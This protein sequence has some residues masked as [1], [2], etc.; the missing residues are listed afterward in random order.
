[1][2]EELVNAWM[3]NNPGKT[4]DQAINA[5]SQS[6]GGKNQVYLGSSKKEIIL[7][8]M[9]ELDKATGLPSKRK[10]EFVESPDILSTEQMYLKF[11]TDKTTKSKAMALLKAMGQSHLGE[12]GA[13]QV[14]KNKVDESAEIYAGGKGY[15]VTP[16]ELT[17]MTIGSLNLGKLPESDTTKYISRTTDA[18]KT[19]TLDDEVQNLLGRKLTSAE[20]KE[21]LASV[22]KLENKGTVTSSKTDP[23]TGMKTVLQEDKY[24]PADVTALVKDKFQGT[25]DYMQKQSLDFMGFLS[26]LGG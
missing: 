13:Y 23:K 19:A 20:T 6:A 24:T 11:W 25:E 8:T 4:R 9:A 17:N 16:Y 10:Q 2:D 1:M 18:Q 21:L 22:K 15:A 14:W 7:N 26:K 3:D 12:V 5:L